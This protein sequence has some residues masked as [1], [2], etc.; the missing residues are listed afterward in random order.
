MKKSKLI[1]MMSLT[2][3]TS[4]V[5]WK[6]SRQNTN[7]DVVKDME[8]LVKLLKDGEGSLLVGGYE[9]TKQHVSQEKN[10]ILT[11]TK[12][13]S[14]NVDA[15]FN[16]G[17]RWSELEDQ[18]LVE[19]IER[20]LL[21]SMALSS[22]K[23]NDV[24]DDLMIACREKTRMTITNA[25]DLYGSDQS[26]Q[27]L[28][29]RICQQDQIDWFMSNHVYSE[30]NVSEDE[31]KAYYEQNINEFKQPKM[32]TFRHMQFANERNAKNVLYRTTWRNF[33]AKARKFSISPD[34]GNGG[35]L[36]PFSAETIPPIFA[37][38]LKMRKKRVSKIIKSPYGYHIIMVLKKHKEKVLAFNESKADIIEKLLNEKKQRKYQQWLQLALNSVEIRKI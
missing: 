8:H 6:V 38:A 26:K 36:G 33:E 23:M 24:I 30:I 37:S 35:I 14:E 10:T 7:I 32:V 2:M 29:R 22:K 28:E 4:F 1:I 27:I 20:Q 3:L 19:M 16:E 15:D 25:P 9:I 21:A 18:V 5:F 13:I 31:A 12:Q 34:A 17:D 11:I